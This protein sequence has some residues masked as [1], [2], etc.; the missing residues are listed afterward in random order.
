MLFAFPQLFRQSWN[1]NYLLR[2][3]LHRIFS[4]LLPG[5]P[6]QTLLDLILPP[7]RRPPLANPFLVPNHIANT[8]RNI[9]DT[10]TSVPSRR[11]FRKLVRTLKVITWNRIIAEVPDVRINFV[12]T[13]RLPFRNFPCLCTEEKLWLASLNG[14]TSGLDLTHVANH[15]PLDTLML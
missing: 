13:T 5:N 15:L 8:D 9:Q 12:A 6:F 7:P 2:I 11:Y 3:I 10:K 14:L 4:T 1:F